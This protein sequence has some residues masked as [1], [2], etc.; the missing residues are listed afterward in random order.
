M[1]LRPFRLVPVLVAVCCCWSPAIR[2][3]AGRD[4]AGHRD[5]L[6]LGRRG[7][8]PRPVHAGWIRDA[9][10]RAL[11]H[12]ER[13]RGDGEDPH[14]P[15]DLVPD[16][17]GGGLR[18]RLRHRATTSSAPAAGSW[19]TTT[20]PVDY[21][22]LAYSNT[23]FEAHLLLP[24]RLLR[25]L[26]GDRLRRDARPHQVHRA[27]SSSASC[28]PAFI[29]P[30]V[31]H[32]TWGGGWLLQDGYQDFA[33]SSIVHLQ[34]A[35]AAAAGTLLLGPRIGKFRDG[36]S[37]PIPGHSIPLMILGVLILW[38]GWMGFNPGSFLNAIGANFAD[39]AVNTN[40]AAAAG[41]IGA[42][43]SALLL[44]KTLDVSQMGNGALAALVAITA[45]CAFVD[46]WAAVVIGLVAGLIVPPLVLARRQAQ[47]RRPGRR[48]AGARH[49]RIWGTLACGL[50]ADRRP[51]GRPSRVGEAGLFD[52]GGGHQLWVQFYGV[53]ATI[54]L[55]V[56]AAPS[57]CSRRS[58]TPS[59]C[60]SARRT[61]C[62]ASTSPSTGCSATPSASSTCPG[63]EPEDVRL[64]P[65]PPAR[66]APLRRPA[67][68]RLVEESETVKKIEAFIRHEALEAIH[69]R[70][71]TMGL[72]SMSVTRGQG[73]GASEGLHREL[74]RRQDHHL[75]ASQAQAG[76]GARRRGRRSRDR[77]H[78]RARPHGRAGG[79]QDLHLPRRGVD[80]GPHRASAATS[81]SPRTREE[82]AHGLA[83]GAG[84]SSEQ[85]AARR[86]DRAARMDL[87]VRRPS[88]RR[89]LP[90]SASSPVYARP[91]AEALPVP[92][93]S[94]PARAAPRA[95]ELPEVTGNRGGSAARRS[96]VRRT[97][98]SPRRSRPAGRAA[99]CAETRPAA[100]QPRTR[101]L[102]RPS[103][104]ASPRLERR[105]NDAPR[106]R[107]WRLIARPRPLPCRP[108]ASPRPE[109]L[110]DAL[111]GGRDARA[112]VADRAR[113]AGGAPPGARPPAGS[114][115]S[116]CRAGCPRSAARASRR[117][118]PAAASSMPRS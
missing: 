14:Q 64:L 43:I 6:D 18:D 7:R 23:N 47:D 75:P 101:P 111:L 70:L 103:V 38:V 11:A 78:P 52:G 109:G 54:A 77:H 84:A 24:G 8:D 65:R 39:V 99:G 40:L 55:H 80:P 36:K 20:P 41:V 105:S 95:G 86:R 15:V 96:C 116:R 12:E 21:A 114:S 97:R 22:S 19:T 32:W 25:G 100:R 2:R 108:S 62:A 31:A 4:P 66:R 102:P 107:S 58:S 67:R 93:P 74:P 85:R 17:L 53:C 16:V 115:G 13:R 89:S 10:G 49:G 72:P 48:P 98:G 91:G 61:S 73:L 45:P 51:R 33:G 76:D 26:A 57:S 79:R 110:E 42:T 3:R 113:P 34:G 106:G 92:R 81:C 27:T 71:A 88:A 87:G 112:G 83:A 82:T 68:H 59:A 28:S 9:R 35:L 63:A 94:G 5:Q 29:Y 1:R 104:R 118:R 50:F 46:P 117:S 30:T 69:D 60:A 37:V 90:A 56:H 44:F